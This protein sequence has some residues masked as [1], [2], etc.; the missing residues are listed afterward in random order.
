MAAEADKQWRIDNARHLRGVRL[1][2]RRYT[3][4]S[5]SWDHDH[6][7]ACTVKFAEFDGPDIQREGY[8]TEDDYP[9]GACYDWV[10]QKCFQDLRDDMK[11]TVAPDNPI[12]DP[13]KSSTNC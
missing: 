8:A 10:C 11:W 3:H 1:Q 12:S 13:A 4:W 5:E 6:C 7:A 2:L 9:R